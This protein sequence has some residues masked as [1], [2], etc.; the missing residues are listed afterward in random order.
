MRT[1]L[2]KHVLASAVASAAVIFVAGGIAFAHIDPDPIAMEAGTTGTVAFTV[3]HGCDGSPMT[4]VKFEIPDGVS[5]VTPVDK[6]G[7]TATVTGKTVEFQGGPMAADDEDHFDITLTAPAQPGEVH[8]PA[9]QTCEQG[10]LAWIEIPAEGAA[11]PE[12]PAPTLKITE[13]PPTAEDLTP[14]PEEEEAT[15]ET[16]I[17]TAV[18]AATSDDDSS[19]TGAIIAVVVGAAAVL[20]GGGVLLA[21]RKNATPKTEPK[22]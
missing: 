12:N 11:E 13:G 6:D 4:S 18:A 3:E 14:E 7:W 10:E 21:R 19:N 9:I 8:F 1:A 15:H 2:F 17:S 5:G 20:I 22:T 16:A